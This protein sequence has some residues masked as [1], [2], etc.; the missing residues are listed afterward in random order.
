MIFIVSMEGSVYDLAEKSGG[1]ESRL[2]VNMWMI[3]GAAFIWGVR[4][5]VVYFRS[6]VRYKVKL[7]N[8]FTRGKFFRAWKDVPRFPDCLI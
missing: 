7:F 6:A 3:L 2:A 4:W 5:H 8:I 1:R